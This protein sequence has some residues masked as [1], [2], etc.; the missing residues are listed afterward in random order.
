MLVWA[1]DFRDCLGNLAS[2]P[3]E[4]LRLV[5]D[6]EVLSFCSESPAHC[7]KSFSGIVGFP[8][9]HNLGLILCV[10]YEA[11]W[12]GDVAILLDEFD[13]LASQL[14]LL[15]FPEELA[16][17]GASAGP[18]SFAVEAT[19]AGELAAAGASAGSSSFASEAASVFTWLPLSSLFTASA[20]VSATSA[21]SA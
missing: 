15:S 8:I 21:G 4:L 1:I 6:V 19:T 7:E 14:R 9:G 17:A 10:G 3:S 20:V 5:N 2:D 13:P 12:F 16:A 11:C 18:S